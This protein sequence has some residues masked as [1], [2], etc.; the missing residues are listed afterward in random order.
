MPRCGLMLTRPVKVDGQ[1]FRV[2]VAGRLR[3]LR[4][5]E[6][7]GPPRFGREVGQDGLPNA[8]VIQYWEKWTRARLPQ[9]LTSSP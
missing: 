3:G 7:V 5:R 8:V 6:V 4:Q 1:K 2:L 9:S